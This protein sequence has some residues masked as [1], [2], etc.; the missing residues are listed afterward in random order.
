MID[1]ETALLSE[2][3]HEENLVGEKVWKKSRGRMRMEGGY[4]AI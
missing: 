4:E 3:M 1:Y 2:E